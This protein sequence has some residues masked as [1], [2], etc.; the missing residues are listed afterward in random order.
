MVTELNL[1]QQMDAER[2]A[3]GQ[4]WFLLKYEELT[5]SADRKQ[6]TLPANFLNFPQWDGVLFLPAA[7]TSDPTAMVRSTRFLPSQTFLGQHDTASGA[8]WSQQGSTINFASAL[9]VGDVPVIIY[10]GSEVLNESA[11]GSGGQPTPNAWMR[12]APDWF[13][14]SLCELFATT[15]LSWDLGEVQTR[16]GPAVAKAAARLVTQNTL[17]EEGGQLRFLNEY[18]ARA[19]AA[20]GGATMEV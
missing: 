20:R 13:I 10:Y 4:M 12:E 17:Q 15:Y 14:A 3:F 9:N 2:S 16:F 1:F 19:A 11:Y 6:A 18:Y 8:G 5:L 7:I